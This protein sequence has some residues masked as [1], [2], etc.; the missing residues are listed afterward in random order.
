MSATI[1]NLTELGN[2]LDAFVYSKD[3]RPVELV[4]YVKC[5]NKVY[6]IVRHKN[7]TCELVFERNLN[8][9]VITFFD[10]YRRNDKFRFLMVLSC[11]QYTEEMQRLDPGLLGGMAREVIPDNSC[12]VF[13]STKKQ[14][15][16]FALLVCQAVD[17]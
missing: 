7:G 17:K 15:S 9:N 3:F 1:G 5:L 13:C 10:L 8:F 11:M 2:F 12:L 14:C 6:R 16:H 4:E